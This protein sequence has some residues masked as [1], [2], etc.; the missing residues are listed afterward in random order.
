MIDLLFDADLRVKLD[1]K[2]AI[3]RQSKD[4]YFVLPKSLKLYHWLDREILDYDFNIR[5]K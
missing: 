2:W 4:S 5:T 3:K 1:D